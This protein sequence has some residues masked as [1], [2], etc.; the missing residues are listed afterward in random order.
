MGAG[1]NKAELQIKRDLFRRELKAL[2][3]ITVECFT[4]QHYATAHGPTCSMF[5]AT[6][7]ADVVKTGCDEWIHDPIPF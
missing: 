7:P 5:N 4:C 2:E 6:P 1:M 3:S